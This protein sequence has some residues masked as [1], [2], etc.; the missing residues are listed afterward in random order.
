MSNV[1]LQDPRVDVCVYFIAPHRLKQIDIEFM[2]Q[3][4]AVRAVSQLLPS[5]MCVCASVSHLLGSRRHHV[6]PPVLHKVKV[7]R[8]AP[9]VGKTGVDQQR[10]STGGGLHH[11]LLGDNEGYVSL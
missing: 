3:L 1:W 11:V 6:W 2:K 5:V 7:N 10:S 4:S 8:V 9:N